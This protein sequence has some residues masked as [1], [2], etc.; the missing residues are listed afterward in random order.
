[1][2]RGRQKRLRALRQFADGVLALSDEPDLASVRRYLAASRA[3]DESR[4]A[5]R[6][7]AH[8]SVSREGQTSHAA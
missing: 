2:T 1:M 7:A 8:D 6:V 4:L 3:L 5:P